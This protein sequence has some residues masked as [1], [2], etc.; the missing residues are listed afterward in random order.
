MRFV[1]NCWTHFPQRSFLLRLSVHLISKLRFTFYW[2]SSSCFLFVHKKIPL[3]CLLMAVQMRQLSERVDV[4]LWV[5]IHRCCDFLGG[6][7]CHSV[8]GRDRLGS[9][10]AEGF[11]A[12]R[13]SIM[14]L[15]HCSSLTKIS[16][17]SFKWCILETIWSLSLGGIPGCCPSLLDCRLKRILS[18]A[19]F[20][21]CSLIS[22][23]A[24]NPVEKELKSCSRVCISSI[25]LLH[26]FVEAKSSLYLCT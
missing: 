25:T 18:I 20:W 16:I 7:F 10:A 19:L 9:R 26:A 21:R 3:N 4:N 14:L 24:N 13:L 6:F 15:L 11:T 17:S 12:P 8:E 1:L 23:S 22:K 2:S 5:R